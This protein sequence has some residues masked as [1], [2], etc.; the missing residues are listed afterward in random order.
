[1]GFKVVGLECDEHISLQQKAAHTHTHTH[2]LSLS[3]SLPYSEQATHNNRVIAALAP[4]IMMA[5]SNSKQ[6]K[7]LKIWKMF[8]EVPKEFSTQGENTNTRSW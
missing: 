6:T 2:S 7:S 1:L 5:S 8:H 4:L 3:L